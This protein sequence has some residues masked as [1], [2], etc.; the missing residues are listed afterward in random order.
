MNFY[1]FRE[2]LQ[3]LKSGL[4]EILAYC[5]VAEEDNGSLVFSV[6]CGEGGVA[7]GSAVVP[8][9]LLVVSFF[10]MPA[11]ADGRVFCDLVMVFDGQFD[12]GSELLM[13]WVQMFL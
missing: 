13:M 1:S 2:V 12:G 8:D 6:E 11:Q 10:D 7:A 9:E 3:E 5:C 4:S